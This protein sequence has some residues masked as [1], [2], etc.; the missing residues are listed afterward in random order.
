M[1]IYDLYAILLTCLLVL[2]FQRAGGALMIYR[3]IRVI[4]CPETA[5]PAAVG[6]RA[7]RVAASAILR[8]PL[9]IGECSRWPERGDC[10]QACVRAIQADPAA[11]L[12]TT[13][14]AGWWQNR[15]CV[16][17]GAS[18][19]KIRP[20]RHSPCFMGPGLR[21][22]EWKDI[23]PQNIPEMLASSRPVCRTCLVAETH[24]W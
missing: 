16:C 9:R 23:A 12:V 7:W 2:C 18:L 11:S 8:T 15:S 13:I 19:K 14:L 3:G 20:G 24:T 21:M 17:C 4:Q 22:I 1:V 6:L 5:Q 10:D